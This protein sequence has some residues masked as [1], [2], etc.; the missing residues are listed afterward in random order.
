MA[1]L[2]TTELK[3]IVTLSSAG[4]TLTINAPIKPAYTYPIAAGN[5]G[6]IIDGT[7]I[8][9]NNEV[10]ANGIAKIYSTINL[11]AG[12][13]LVNGFTLA[14]CPV[15]T[16]ITF[17]ESFLENTTSASVKEVYSIV[18]NCSPSS[19]T[20]LTTMS[21]N[22][23]AIIPVVVTSSVSLIMI[24]KFTGSAPYVFNHEFRFK[25]IRIA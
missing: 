10:F 1:T 22:C 14:S 5:I 25:A 4:G 3:G 13:W 19:P 12:T 2:A 18:Q 17:V 6:Y 23:T 16:N 11:T 21:F 9:S 15:G 7:L 8:P 20:T 24:C